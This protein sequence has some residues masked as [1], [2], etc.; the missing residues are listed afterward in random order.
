MTTDDNPRLIYASVRS[1]SVIVMNAHMLHGASLNHDGR[2]RR[3]IHVYYTRQG[4]HTQTDWSIYV[5]RN[6]KSS[7][8]VEEQKILGL[9]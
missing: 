9:S 6:V 2:R 8:T 3:V 7:L 5:P 1:G 4:R